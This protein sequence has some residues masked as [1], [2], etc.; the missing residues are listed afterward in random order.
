MLPS[1]DS[2]VCAFQSQFNTFVLALRQQYGVKVKTFRQVIE[3]HRA[4]L[5]NKQSYWNEALTVIS[6]K[7]HHFLCP[8]VTNTKNV[9]TYTAT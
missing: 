2:G 1:T 8:R 4:E 3:V 6:D 7:L 9:Y 5:E